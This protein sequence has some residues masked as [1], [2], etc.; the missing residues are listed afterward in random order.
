MKDENEEIEQIEQMNTEGSL[1][2]LLLKQLVPSIV[3][4]VAL[5]IVGYGQS[6]I[7][8]GV[9]LEDQTKSIM[10]YVMGVVMVISAVGVLMRL[11]PKS[12]NKIIR[13]NRK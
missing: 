1:L 12:N 2:F 9:G 11:I 3:A 10:T 7:R 5:G 4:L 6:L 13:H 8:F